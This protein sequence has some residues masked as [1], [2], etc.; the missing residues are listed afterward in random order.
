MQGNKR[1]HTG[2]D[3]LCVIAFRFASEQSLL[4]MCLVFSNLYVDMM[5]NNSL[6]LHYIQQ[7]KSSR[8]VLLSYSPTKLLS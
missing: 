8:T 2:L 1:M 3:V 5:G 7:E 4:E 6:S